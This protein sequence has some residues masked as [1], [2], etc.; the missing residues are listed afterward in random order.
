MMTE[1]R[2]GEVLRRI[3]L[4]SR[5]KPGPII[6]VMSCPDERVPGLLENTNQ[7]RQVRAGRPFRGHPARAHAMV[8]RAAY[9]PAAHRKR[10]VVG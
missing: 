4:A 1:M 10:A 6:L 7:Q 3:Y 2:R 9:A 5:A 8:W